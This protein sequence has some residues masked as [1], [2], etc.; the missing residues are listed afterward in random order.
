MVLPLQLSIMEFNFS[1]T[2]IVIFLFFCL[3]IGATDELSS[4]PSGFQA[5]NNGRTRSYSGISFSK[6]GKTLFHTITWKKDSTGPLQSKIAVSTWKNNAWSEPLVLH[7]T[8]GSEYYP[9]LSADENRLYFSSFAP[10][11]GKTGNDLNIWYSEKKEKGWGAPVP[12]TELNSEKNERI[13]YVGNR[14]FYI[15]SDRSGDYDIYSTHL[16]NGQWSA[17]QPETQWNSKA[18]EEYVSVY[19]GYGI[20]FVQRTQPTGETGIFYSTKT[21]QHWSEPQALEYEGKFTKAP[22]VH[23]FPCLSPDGGTFYVNTGTRLWQR[24]FKKI[25]KKNS[26]SLHVTIPAYRPLPH[27]PRANGEPELFGS[28]LLKTNNGISF[29][30]DM[31]TLYLSRYTQEKD[32]AG[33]QF[34]KLFESRYANNTWSDPVPL[35]FNEPATPF[36]YHPVVSPDGHTIFYNSRRA[37]PGSAVKY[38]AKNNLWYV[39]RLPDGGWSSPIMIKEIATPEYDDYATVARSGNLYFRSDRP[40]GKGG[41]DI[42]V[43]RLLNGTYQKP[44]AVIDINSKH[45]ENDLCVD[46]GERFIIFN[47]YIDATEEMQLYLSI[48]TGNGWSPPR[49]IYQLERADEWELTPTLSPDGKYFFYEVNANIQR[50]E[51]SSLFSTEEK[52][53][54]KLKS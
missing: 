6:D 34:I 33:R 53:L 42:Y 25:L 38:Y 28:I 29:A 48:R 50:V 24:S 5:F 45:N 32:S 40:G 20:A 21:D 14:V 7:F 4:L 12:A 51:L 30:P 27:K 46:P 11:P 35:P 49:M 3:F 36:E 23:R 47:R 8:N 26:L 17:L 10:I 16:R 18:Q 39:N 2:T 52:K 9:M 41:G 13:T 15:T 1:R 54:L 19:D 22:Y 37:E 43:S 44:E 31:K